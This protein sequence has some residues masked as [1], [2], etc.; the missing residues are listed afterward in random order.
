MKRK[1]F[2]R[3]LAI[4][5]TAVSAMLAYRYYLLPRIRHARR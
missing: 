2:L 1:T 3:W 5:D 4:T